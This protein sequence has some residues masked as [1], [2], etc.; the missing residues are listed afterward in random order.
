MSTKNDVGVIDSESRF[1]G[2]NYTAHRI[3]QATQDGGKFIA[4]VGSGHLTTGS[5]KVTGLA[6]LLTCPS[7][8]IS[9][10]DS[11]TTVEINCP[12]F[13]SEK[14]FIENVSLHIYHNVDDIFDLEKEFA[15]YPMIGNN[16]ENKNGNKSATNKPLNPIIAANHNSEEFNI[17][18]KSNQQ[19]SDSNYKYYIPAGIAS[20]IFIAYDYYSFKPSQKR[21]KK[22][23]KT[24]PIKLDTEEESL[25]KKDIS[26][27]SKI[28]SKESNPTHYFHHL[29]RHPS[30]HKKTFAGLLGLSLSLLSAMIK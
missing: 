5:A 8:L 26:K 18:L 19:P 2:M 11:E 14:N 6:E 28:I 10:S 7:V 30:Q 17:N 12:K 27:E 29:R 15:E 24:K 25:I 21:L 1:L 20:T 22:K 9:D 23:D 3:I 13:E 16:P 4:L